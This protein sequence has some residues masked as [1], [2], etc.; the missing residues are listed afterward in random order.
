[1]TI[2]VADIGA[3]Y[4]RFALTEPEGPVPDPDT[5]MVADEGSLEEA[6]SR[7]LER[8]GAAGVKIDAAVLA[9]AGPV[10]ADG[11]I[12]MTNG[13]WTINP[14]TIAE[15]L[16]A[17][18]IRVLNDMTAAA[19][20]LP[21][22]AADELDKLGGGEAIP[23]APKAIIAPGTGLGVSALVPGTDGKAVSLAS[24]GGHVDLAPHDAREGAIVL[25]L[26]RRYGH[27][28]PERVLSGQGL[29]A[30]YAALGA[31][32]GTDTAAKGAADIAAAARRGEAQAVET[33]QLF[34]GWLGSV[35]GDL[36]LTLGARGGVY[37]GGGIVPQ[38]GELFDRALF[39]R[40]FEAKGRFS[41]LLAS[42]PAFLVQ[43]KDVVL[44]GC[45]A[46]ARRLVG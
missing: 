23:H 39:R 28:S 7:F 37:V 12:Q 46:E 2:L 41:D 17:R 13:P 8:R 27:A 42:I 25:H 38:W 3:T 1:M 26:L 15:T 34:C 4:A 29:E 45:Q 20:G 22:L 5:V 10:R 16:N 43:R 32:D 19:L 6:V 9:A 33:L 18:S 31:L 35:A 36:A 11:T 24:E 21:L 44:L 40:R 30:L 14:Q